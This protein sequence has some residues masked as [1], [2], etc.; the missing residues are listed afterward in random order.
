M[1]SSFCPVFSWLLVNYEGSGPSLH[2]GATAVLS[3]VWVGVGVWG[4]KR[5]GGGRGDAPP[6]MTAN[7]DRLF[8]IYTDLIKSNQSSAT[9]GRNWPEL[10]SKHLI[11]RI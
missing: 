11:I 6:T 9:R 5:E 2:P 8:E 10:I 1:L 4:T 7:Q 3:F